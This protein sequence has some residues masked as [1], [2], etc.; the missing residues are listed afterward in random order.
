MG[1]IRTTLLPY[2]AILAGITFV[3]GSDGGAA[4][5]DESQ[6]NRILVAP[7]SVQAVLITY[8]FSCHDAGT[9]EGDV[10]LDN[11]SSLTLD[12]QLDLLNR[13]QEQL[14]IGDMPPK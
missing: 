11:L 6:Q 13:V 14:L 12:A 5:V 3:S 2:F 1:Q 10:R 9:A 4:G 8:C 7:A